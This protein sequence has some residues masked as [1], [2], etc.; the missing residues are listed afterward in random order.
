M[1]ENFLSKTTFRVSSGFITQHLFYT[2]LRKFHPT[3]WIANADNP[4]GM[5]QI[6]E[7][8]AKT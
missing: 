1:K 5:S 8:K 2:L 7:W 4:S 6:L 3:E